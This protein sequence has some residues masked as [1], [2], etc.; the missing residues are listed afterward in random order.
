MGFTFLLSTHQ[1][2]DGNQRNGIKKAISTKQA[3]GLNQHLTR[4]TNVEN[5]RQKEW[6]QHSF[7]QL[8][9]EQMK[10]GRKETQSHDLNSLVG[11]HDHATKSTQGYS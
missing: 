5:K 6:N 8:I 10:V 2:N 7:D 1:S 3:K 11:H 9:M 4:P